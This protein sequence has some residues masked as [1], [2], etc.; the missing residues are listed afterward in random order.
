MCIE[1]ITLL[2]VSS[3]AHNKRLSTPTVYRAIKEKQLDSEVIDGVTFVVNNDKLV[4]FEPKKRGRK[5]P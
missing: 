3:V 1:T 5:Q 4:T 2:T